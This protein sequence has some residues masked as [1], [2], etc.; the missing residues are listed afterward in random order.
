MHGQQ[1]GDPA[2]AP[3][4][5]DPTCPYQGSYVAARSYHP[6]GVNAVFGDGHVEFYDDAVDLLVWQA[7]STIDGG[8]VISQ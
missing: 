6:G 1:C 4:P 3:A 7:L 2:L 8:E 5:C